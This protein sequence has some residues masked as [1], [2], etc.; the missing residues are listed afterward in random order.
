M[1]GDIMPQQPAALNHLERL[2]ATFLLLK[3]TLADFRASFDTLHPPDFC[4][5][6]SLIID[7][8]RSIS[9]DAHAIVIQPYSLGVDEFSH[10]G[11]RWFKCHKPTP[12]SYHGLDGVID[13]TTQLYRRED[14]PRCLLD[15]Q[16]MRAGLLL[17]KYTYLAG[18]VM[19]KAAA[20]DTYRGAASM[21]DIARVVGVKHAQMHRDVVSIQEHTSSDYA[22]ILEQGIESLE[23]PEE[24]KSVSVM[25]D[26]VS[27]AMEE[28]VARSVGRPKKNAAKRPV[29]RNFRMAYASV[30]SWHDE[31]GGTL[32]S[33]RLAALPE[34]GD[35]LVVTTQRVLAKLMQYTPR[36]LKLMTL[37][38]GAE[39]MQ[40]KLREITKS[41]NV[42][43]R[44]TDY[45]HTLEY[46]APALKEC[47]PKEWMSWMK[48]LKK[49][50]LE[51]KRGAETVLRHLRNMREESERRSLPETNAAI[52]YME[53]HLELMNYA[54]AR[55]QGLPVGSGV[56]EASCKTIVEV[57]MKRCGMRWKKP[58]A[59]GVM[60]LRAMSTSVAPFWHAAYH[61]L[62]R[63]Y[64]ETLSAAA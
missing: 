59:Q 55:A 3:A 8:V 44:L 45:W 48:L 4:D 1:P 6:E 10:Q 11:H 37:G 34:Q 31:E 49:G 60:R 26:R 38:D 27:V 21:L 42:D 54:G 50:L 2:D 19:L 24:A 57:R 25:L 62:A 61:R 64:V 56:V 40:N 18:K 43:M 28:P 47:I 35:A 22:E 30:V 7:L 63:C 58:G 20:D 5:V 12:V 14:D 53:N 29:A 16:A 33:V 39:E 13:T 32:G 41:F 51:G 17:Q 9:C 36:P 52:T 46:L 15:P 23:I